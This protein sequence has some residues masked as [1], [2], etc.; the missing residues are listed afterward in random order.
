M[1]NPLQFWKIVKEIN[2]A[3]IREESELPFR[4][5]AIG[6]GEQMELLRRLAGLEPLLERQ[7]AGQAWYEAGL[8]LTDTAWTWLPRCRFALSLSDIPDAPVSVWRLEPQNPEVYTLQIRSI[9]NR[10]K[11]LALALPRAVPMFR[12][13]ASER[14]IQATA[15]TNTKIAVASALPGVLPAIAFLLPVTSVPDMALL[16]KNQMMMCLRLAAVYGLDIDLTARMRE[17]GPVVGAAFGWRAL[18]REIVGV[19][20]GGFG[21]VA[22]GGIAYAATVATGRA[23]RALFETGQRPTDA[24]RRAWYHEALEKGRVVAT[25]AFRRARNRDE[26]KPAP[27]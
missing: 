27:A 21:A 17:L 11:D 10:H 25:D 23:A 16:T 14:V 1:P 8:P 12:R 24:Q 5:A 6:T 22:K 2:P 9:L 26:P 13:E 15:V 7:K 20:P 18:A 19:V 4:V 3:T